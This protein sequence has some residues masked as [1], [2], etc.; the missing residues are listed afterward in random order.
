MEQTSQ[1]AEVIGMDA[2]S[3]KIS[4]CLMRKVGGK[5]VKV[6]TIATT[7]DALEATYARQMPPGVLTVLE[8]STNS[9]SIVRRLGAMGRP[10]KQLCA[11]VLSGL[12]RQDRVNDR[13]DAEKLA[14]AYLR[15]GPE[16]REVFTPSP[17]GTDRRETYFAYRDARKDETRAANRIWS[18]CSRHGL[19]VDR[20]IGKRRCAA[21]LAEGG[22][23]GWSE[24]VMERARGLVSD[25]ER[26]DAVCR[27]RGRAIEREVFANP[28]MTRLQQVP[29]VRFIG[30]FALVAFVED[31]RRFAS[32]KKLVSYIGLNPSVC[33]SGEKE[34]KREVSKFGRSDLKAIFV[35]AAQSAMR[36][37]SPAAR[38]AKRLLARGKEWNVAIAALARKLAVLCW[39]ILMGHPAPSRER[40]CATAAKLGRLAFCVGKEAVRRAGFAS[41]TEFVAARC[42]MLYG[43]LPETVKGEGRLCSNA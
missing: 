9:V 26:A 40:Q 34:A 29:G 31:V 7:L 27:E 11:D 24:A 20:K 38:W 32:P 6:K 16:L 3:R 25:W 19:D 15:Y 5:I 18:F 13:I 17:C 21:L 43:H 35:E 1:I 10:A 4:L 12:S 28:D 2:H 33:G 14:R 30:A 37:D 39:H 23:R 41:A 8:A 42:S 22:A 36:T